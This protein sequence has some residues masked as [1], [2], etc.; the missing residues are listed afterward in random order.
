MRYSL[1]DD[2]RFTASPIQ[3]QTGC[4][5]YGASASDT[6]EAPDLHGSGA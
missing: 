3:R 4:V 6:H 1:F 2:W 5:A